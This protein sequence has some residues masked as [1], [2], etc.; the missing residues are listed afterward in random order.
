M[1][2]LE[3]ANG[4]E[5][6]EDDD[7]GFALMKN[8]SSSSSPSKPKTKTKDDY[9]KFRKLTDDSKIDEIF[10]G[11]LR[12]RVLCP[13][14]G[15]DSVN[16]E[17]FRVLS[18]EIPKT[19]ESSSSTS[20]AAGD[21]SSTIDLVN[22]NNNNES[23]S[24]SSSSSYPVYTF[25]P[26]RYDTSSSS[27]SPS[28]S[29]AP[30][31]LPAAVRGNPVIHEPF[32]VFP[33]SERE[34]WGGDDDV[35]NNNNNNN[36][37]Q[38]FGRPFTAKRC[39]LSSRHYVF[40]RLAPEI[41]DANTKLPSIT[42]VT[43]NG[44]AV[45]SST[46]EAWLR[47]AYEQPRAFLNPIGDEPKSV[48]VDGS[49]TPNKKDDVFFIWNR[50]HGSEAFTGMPLAYHRTPALNRYLVKNSNFFSFLKDYVGFNLDESEGFL[51]VYAVGAL[52]SSGFLGKKIECDDGEVVEWLGYGPG[53]EFV[54]LD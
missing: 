36:D 24:S 44:F 43:S 47:V 4:N 48:S 9:L 3:D 11:I 33:R 19:P 22:N 6:D 46:I 25:P 21:A 1:E 7:D 12:S 15:L 26:T 10:Q 39:A 27:S 29:S 37:P 17:P 51:G 38:G 18:L 28:S 31:T 13:E 30:R 32:L 34:G 35:N 42:H 40:I 5:A 20:G 52:K 54:N 49:S 14:C 23:S 8:S 2:S 41:N 45:N 53:C 16:Y 50:V